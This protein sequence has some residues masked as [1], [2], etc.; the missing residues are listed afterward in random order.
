MEIN[1]MSF[2]SLSLQRKLT[3]LSLTRPKL[4]LA[5]LRTQIGNMRQSYPPIEAVLNPNPHPIECGIRCEH[6][7]RKYA[8]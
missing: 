6:L 1:E 8:W 4:D 2:V 7:R 5:R 3:E